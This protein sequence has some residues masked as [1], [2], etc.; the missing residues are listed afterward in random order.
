MSI[1]EDK[2]RTFDKMTDAGPVDTNGRLIETCIERVHR[3][4]SSYNCGRKLK[5]DP[6]FPHLCGIHVGAIH[7]TRAKIA[8]RNQY[9][10][11]TAALTQ[12]TK[13]RADAAAAALGVQLQV[14][15][16]HETTGPN[17]Y[18]SRPSGRVSISLDE[19]EQLVKRL[20]Q[21]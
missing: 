2:V 3:D 11:E 14:E 20:E 6:E 10:N 5:G 7:R 1:Y 15:S 4:Y 9:A 13:E 18:V 17:A 16:T 21:A 8:K 12:S 19:L